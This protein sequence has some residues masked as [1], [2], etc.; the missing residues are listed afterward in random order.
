MTDKSLDAC[1]QK[2]LAK[3][4]MQIKENKELVFDDHEITQS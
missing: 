1:N 4:G 2:K 3:E